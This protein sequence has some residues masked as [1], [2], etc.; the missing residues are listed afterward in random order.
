MFLHTVTVKVSLNFEHKLYRYH[1]GWPVL[2][3]WFDNCECFT[4]NSFIQ[5][6]LLYTFNNSLYRC[7]LCMNYILTWIVLVGTFQIGIYKVAS[8]IKNPRMYC[9]I[10]QW[11]ACN[12]F[13][14]TENYRFYW[15]WHFNEYC[16]QASKF[17]ENS[18]ILDMH[19]LGDWLF[20]K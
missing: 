20:I 5:F 17:M 12:K 14:F 1:S 4:Q 11:I 13:E 15:I 19:S 18:F 9:L 7:D 2:M 10:I 8:Q 16:F 6:L 3:Y